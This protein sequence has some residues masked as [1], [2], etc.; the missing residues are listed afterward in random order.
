M[1]LFKFLQVYPVVGATVSIQ[2]SLWQ[3][4]D[5][6]IHVKLTEPTDLGIIMASLPADCNSAM[7]PAAAPPG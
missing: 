2:R 3:G 1:F 7:E 5:F 6:K 4:I